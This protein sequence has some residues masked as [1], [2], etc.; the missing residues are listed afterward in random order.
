MNLKLFIIIVINLALLTL[1]FAMS[2]D[3]SEYPEIEEVVEQVEQLENIKS[4]QTKALEA[5]QVRA[6]E[7]TK[8]K[9]LAVAEAKE[10]EQVAETA[11]AQEKKENE[12]NK[13]EVSQLLQEQQKSEQKI[14][15]LVSQLA[16]FQNKNVSLIGEVE[17][18]NVQLT[19]QTSQINDLEEN[20]RKRQEEEA[21][22]LVSESELLKTSIES[23]PDLI[24]ATTSESG[25]DNT[26]ENTTIDNTT[27]KTVSNKVVNKPTENK[28]EHVD[29]KEPIDPFSGTVEFGFSYEQ[30]TQ[31]DQAVNGR[32]ILNYER[33]DFYKL[34][35]NLKFEIEDEDDERSTEKIRWQLQWDRYFDP[36]NSFFMLSDIKRSQFS[37]YKQED[38]YTT[39]YGRIVFNLDKHKLNYEVGPG[40]R[41]AVPNDDDDDDLSIDEVILRGKLNY[42]RILSDSL[43]VKMNAVWVWGKENSTYSASF[44]AQNKIYRELYLIFDTEY[45]YTQNV[46]DDSSN[47]EFS[48]GL[49]LMYAF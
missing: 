19:K 17:H 32:L 8:A 20:I 22:L 5:A 37:S 41:V 3:D 24:E 4:T 15:L 47:D 44:T 12:A 29:T 49:K 28:P 13:K 43:Q 1:T 33:A 9:E 11:L 16:L 10:L 39:G 34:N 25:I 26:T 42:E 35:S 40:Y 18:L 23:Q 46:S 45:E 2:V 38:T 7:A 36:D 30:N 6:L 31:V 48:S 14:A 27:G 21:S